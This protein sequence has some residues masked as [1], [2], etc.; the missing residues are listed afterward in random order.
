MNGLLL[1]SADWPKLAR[2]GSRNI[3]EQHHYVDDPF[4]ATMFKEKRLTKLKQDYL[5]GSSMGNGSGSDDNK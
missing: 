2:K 1:Y 4:F 5:P 3:L